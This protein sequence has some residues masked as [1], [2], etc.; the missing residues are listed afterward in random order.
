M[1]N[2]V[3]IDFADFAPRR[4]LRALLIES[5]ECIE[6]N[7]VEFAPR[8]PLRALLIESDNALNKTSWTLLLSGL[9]VPY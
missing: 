7:F 6:Q 3:E 1:V 9:C 4:S 8:R 2:G 5:R